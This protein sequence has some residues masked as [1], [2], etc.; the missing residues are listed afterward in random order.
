ME[1]R[2]PNSTIDLNF[3]FVLHESLPSSFFYAGD[4][5]SMFRVEYILNV[6]MLGLT[7]TGGPVPSAQIL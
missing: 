2:V 5:M 1:L 4:S 7:S 3:S 6:T